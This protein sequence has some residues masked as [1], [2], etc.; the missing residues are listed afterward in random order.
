M[1]GGP[2]SMLNEAAQVFS[3]A[4]DEAAKTLDAAYDRMLG[5]AAIATEKLRG[6]AAELERE[7]AQ[8]IDA[9]PDTIARELEDAMR[10]AA[11]SPFTNAEDAYERL[12]RAVGTA[13]RK[14]REAAGALAAQAEREQ[15]IHEGAQ[16]QLQHIADALGLTG[17]ANMSGVLQRAAVLT[18]ENAKL[19]PA[20]EVIETRFTEVHYA[21]G[22]GGEGRTVLR[23]ENLPDVSVTDA[24][25]DRLVAEHAAKSRPKS[26]VEDW[27]ERY[28]S[29][30]RAGGP[31]R[32]G[33]KP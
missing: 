10:H 5:V 18:H 13:T 2:R 22:A 3:D 27:H 17:K 32:G 19:G 21:I 4:A 30:R 16:E 8:T 14:L 33:E 15:K 25:A 23:F 20:P 12:L 1:T 31:N 28:E 26:S 6:M 24:D 9:Q 7:A 29:W 11:P